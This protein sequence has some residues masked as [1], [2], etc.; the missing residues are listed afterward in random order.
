MLPENAMKKRKSP[1][2]V[3]IALAKKLHANAAASGTLKQVGVGTLIVHGRAT[4]GRATYATWK[5]YLLEA[6]AILRGEDRCPE[7]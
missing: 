2:K 5:S 6:R 4:A 7:S 1:T 3:E